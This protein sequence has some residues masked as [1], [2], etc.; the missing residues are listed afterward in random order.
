ML[1]MLLD[2]SLL[3]QFRQNLTHGILASLVSY[4]VLPFTVAIVLIFY[5]GMSLI[6]ISIS[7]SIILIFF[8]TMIEQGKT[9]ASQERKLAE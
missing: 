2:L 3:L 9:I 7:I 1:G 6:N 5:Y 8:E 4:I